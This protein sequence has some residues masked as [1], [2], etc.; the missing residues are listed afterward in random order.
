MKI[1]RRF[2]LAASI[3]VVA[4]LWGLAVQIRRPSESPIG[5]IGANPYRA[6][7]ASLPPPLPVPFPEP[8][9]GD[10]PQ[11]AW[12]GCQWNRD[13]TPAMIAF[14]DWAA[15]YQ[16][17]P[18]GERPSLLSEGVTAA[19]Q[20]RE[21]LARWIREDPRRALAAAVPVM[22]R[23]T[24]P[25]EVNALL[26]ER[27]SGVGELALIGATPF[28]GKPIPEPTFRKALIAN[29][30]FRAFTY[31]RRHGIPYLPKASILGIAI[32]D[33]L[34]VSDSPVRLLEAGE[35]TG[36]KPVHVSCPPP[37]GHLG[38][39]PTPPWNTDPAAPTAV[40]VNGRI[41]VFC[42]KPAHLTELEAKL[43]EAEGSRELILGNN[44]PGTSGVSGRPAMSWTHGTKTM[45][46]IRVDFS[47]VPGT[48]TNPYDG[49]ASIT[50]NYVLGVVNN[51][52]GVRDFYEEAS[53]G[54]TSLQ[55]STSDVTT[56]LRMPATASSYATGYLVSKLHSDAR[57]KAE[58][59]G[60]VL[61]NYDRIAV[62][63]S[64]LSN[65][66]GSQFTFGGLGSIESKN[67]WV[68]GWWA[69]E[70]VAHEVGH[71]YG[72]HH[73]NLWKV[74]ANDPLAA[75]PGAF[76]EQ[77][78][79]KFDIMGS[80]ATA[81]NHFSHWNKGILQ[82]IPDTAVTTVTQS[83]SYRVHRFDH[84][85]ANLTNALALK[86]V[87]NQ[88]QDYWIGYRRATSNAS[89]DGGA[90]VLW[91]Y[92]ENLEGDLLDLTSPYNDANSTGLPIN[93]THN[94]WLSGIT[95][96]PTGQGGTGNA[97]EWLD[98]FVTLAPRI[99]WAQ[100]TFFADEQSGSVTLTLNREHN[101][102]GQISV[103]YT[104]ED[105]S[106]TSPG[107]Y[108]SQ[109]GTVTWPNGDQSPR[110]I[111]IPIVADALTE[112]SQSFSVIL[113]GATG[114][115]VIS[116]P[117]TATV[118][119]ADPGARDAT[120]IPDFINSTVEKVIVLPDGSIVAGGWFSKVKDGA[121]DRFGIAK[122][123]PTGAFDPGFASG[124]GTGAYQN[125][126]IANP[127]LAIVRQPDGKLL[128]GGDFTVMHGVSRNRIARLDANGDLDN[129]F[130]PGSGANGKVEAVLLQPD[131]KILIGG[132]FTSYNGSAR[133]YLA[134]LNADGSLDAT[135]IG[136]D[137]GNT[138]GWR[139]SSLAR[140]TDGKV[141]VGGEFFFEGPPPAK[142]GLCRVNS[143]G[144]LDTTF[145]GITNGAH[146][147]GSTLSL[148]CVRDIKVLTDGKILIAGDFGAFNGATRGGLA[149][150]TSTGALD[151]A[152]TPTSDGFCYSILPQPDGK[153]LV[154]GSFTTFNGT[155]VSRLVRL[156]SAGVVDTGF[157]AAGG[158]SAA[159]QSLALQ[160]DG[161]VVFG[162]DMATYQGAGNSAPLWRFYAGLPSRP[163][164]LQF[165]SETVT[166]Y[167]DE[168]ATLSVSRSGGSGGE[169]T[170][171]YSTVIGTAGTADFTTTAG[172]LTWANG[173][174]AP[175]TITVPLSLDALSDPGETFFVH[176][177][178]PQLNSAILGTTQR[179]VVTI[180]EP[181]TFA[182]WKED[183]FTPAEIADPNITGP[184]ADAD[185]DGWTTLQEY[186][187][188]SDPK[189][190]TTAPPFISRLDS[191]EGSTYLT[192][193]FR[194]RSTLSDLT[195]LVQTNSGL[196]GT[197]LD[198]DAVLVPGSAV[199]HGDGT[200]TVTYRD[201]QPVSAGPRRFLRLEI[202]LPP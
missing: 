187:F 75:A 153:I 95:I 173:D 139:V 7:P 16:Q 182:A 72:L 123:S 132:G 87:R 196:P 77:Y 98:V 184:N 108:A 96:R 52:G 44:L 30:E 140:L 78:G 194:R 6:S 144:S 17:A 148:R 165:T 179:C 82:W 152:F 25:P 92:N 146:S 56:V 28:P 9:G 45:L 162:A 171:G 161:K 163:G 180:R 183:R 35:P 93:S 119:I 189:T 129:S 135:F 118:T 38:V 21:V 115:A 61:D 159:V 59:A 113:S 32:G 137:F 65:L 155:S 195:Y 60:F 125:N 23:H 5:P 42:C 201:S 136:P 169:L 178:E 10:I 166:G 126:G 151:S 47:D 111:T 51:T 147:A 141:V 185:G 33:A 15:R 84:A 121:T 3:A 8:G 116:E 4:L 57:S 76:S 175:K 89:L 69:F 18:A 50:S 168:I 114:D 124:S 22:V 177:G 66:P 37:R 100:S 130:N 107:D 31:G 102:S 71:N 83:G 90:Y 58:D 150:L 117:S 70:L 101:A 103:N 19:R 158:P 145:N 200:E 88:T 106:A 85:G 127:V 193:T 149:R 29:R 128:V 138:T 80:G 157:V 134:R 202:Q 67:S 174:S 105:G 13:Q 12:I 26:E 43:I 63:F 34:A 2:A 54:K 68:N 24:L 41:E 91:G 181:I 191:I 142:A 172:T 186:A 176:L 160:P 167:E 48:P 190:T 79:D 27:I 74:P 104:T 36:D 170:I 131:G 154:G 109:S 20:R 156:T 53:F 188:A 192:L 164:T 133:E 49:N 64:D 122:F 110:T 11:R 112:G 55:L 14:A 62:V 40:E 120:F 94:D 73:A 143:N 1:P 199:D 198:N 97:D 86:I 81:A 99:S 197:W 39:Q 46:V